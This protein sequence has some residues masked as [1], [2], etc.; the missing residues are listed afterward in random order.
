MFVFVFS[1]LPCPIRTYGY[2]IFNMI[3]S[4]WSKVTFVLIDFLLQVRWKFL[5]CKGPW[6]SFLVFRCND[7]TYC[8]FTSVSLLCM[9]TMLFGSWRFTSTAWHAHN[10]RILNVSYWDPVV[11]GLTE[12]SLQH[13]ITYCNLIL[14]KRFAWF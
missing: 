6:M 14:S 4:N 1:F 9:I 7:P 12:D 13:Y 11:G 5:S 10:W 2:S 3:S 8:H